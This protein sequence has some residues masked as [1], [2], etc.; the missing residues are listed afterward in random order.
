MIQDKDVVNVNEIL[1][2]LSLIIEGVII[3]FFGWDL[4]SCIED[5][6]MVV[7]KF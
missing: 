2:F 1:C 5:I 4:K 7:K 6:I 3:L